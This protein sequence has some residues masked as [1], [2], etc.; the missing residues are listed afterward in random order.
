ML[1]LGGAG[2]ALAKREAK[3]EEQERLTRS[4]YYEVVNAIAAE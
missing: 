3:R 1:G 2:E 4:A